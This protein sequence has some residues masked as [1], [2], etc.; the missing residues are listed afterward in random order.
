MKYILL[1]LTLC[2]AYQNPPIYDDPDCQFDMKPDYC[3]IETMPNTFFNLTLISCCYFETLNG[4]IK[5]CSDHDYKNYMGYYTI[6][7][8]MVV[9][10][11]LCISLFMKDLPICTDHHNNYSRDFE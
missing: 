9:F 1:L 10:I 5:C 11:I 2:Y 4:T 7:G 6:A 3:I 8:V